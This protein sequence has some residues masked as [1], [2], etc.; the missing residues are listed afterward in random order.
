M[1]ITWSRY[2]MFQYSQPHRE[3]LEI[4]DI[5]EKRKNQ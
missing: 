4:G 2:D 1:E 5:T 3:Q